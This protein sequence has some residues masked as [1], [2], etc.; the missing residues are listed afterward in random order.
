[1][2]RKMIAMLT[3]VVLATSLTA[4]GGDEEDCEGLGSSVV[5]A[6]ADVGVAKPRPPRAHSNSKPKPPKAKTPKGRKHGKIDDDLFE[7]CDDD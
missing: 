1:M 4:C 6:A 5:V 7:D 3:T 2:K